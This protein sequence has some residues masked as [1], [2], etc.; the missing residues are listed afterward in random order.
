MIKVRGDREE[1]E[2]SKVIKKWNKR[3]KKEREEGRNWRK[4]YKKTK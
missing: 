4:R 2:G 3:N 1:T